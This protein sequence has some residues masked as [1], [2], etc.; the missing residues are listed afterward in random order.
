MFTSF[1]IISH[2]L[3]FLSLSLHQDNSVH[4]P[5]HQPPNKVIIN[6][7]ILS[8]KK[9]YFI[10]SLF[11]LLHLISFTVLLILRQT[12]K[13]DTKCDNLKK[14]IQSECHSS[15]FYFFLV[16]LWIL[17]CKT[18][19]WHCSVITICC[20]NIANDFNMLNPPLTF[21][22]FFF[23]FVGEIC[24]CCLHFSDTQDLERKFLSSS[25]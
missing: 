23:F 16:F 13:Q 6:L 15:G 18:S 4:P 1:R 8:T 9:K 21:D 14:R 19:N 5:I 7:T 2:C 22:K 20:L 25:V 10:R 3:S 12:K 17:C 24:F 11:P